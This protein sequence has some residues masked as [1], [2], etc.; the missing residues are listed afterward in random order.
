ML[1]YFEPMHPNNHGEE[2]LRNWF[3][4]ARPEDTNSML[5]RGFDPVFSGLRSPSKAWNRAGWHRWIPGY[6]VVVKDVAALMAAEWLYERYKPQMLF[7]VRHPCAVILSEMRQGTPPQESLKALLSNSELVEDSTRNH[8]ATLKQAKGAIEMLAAVWAV[9]HRVIAH[10]LKAHPEWRIVY[11]EALCADPVGQYKQL[12]GS[13]DLRWSQAM[14]TYVEA[15]SA[16]DDGSM[17]SAKKV[18]RQQID[19]WKGHMA[20]ADVERVRALTMALEVP[21]YQAPEAWT[22]EKFLS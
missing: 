15:H 12:F 1:Y 21:F 16:A 11:Y 10:G 2:N 13:L 6:R 9:R 3:R 4:Y 8:L 20:K 14:A 17:Y 22:L 19:R 18:S 5:A 7:I